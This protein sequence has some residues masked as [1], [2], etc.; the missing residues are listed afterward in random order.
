MASDSRQAV[1]PLT[2]ALVLHRAADV[3]PAGDERG[4][5]IIRAAEEP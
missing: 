1:T 2:A 4:D 3:T 5:R